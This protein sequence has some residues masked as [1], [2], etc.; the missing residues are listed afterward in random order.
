[1]NEM[2]GTTPNK[3]QKLFFAEDPSD[4]V[5]FRVVGHSKLIKIDK[6]MVTEASPVIK[7]L[8]QNNVF[9][10]IKPILI[11][12]TTDFD[13]LTGFL[14]FVEALHEKDPKSWL[15]NPNNWEDN[16]FTFG[17]NRVR[18]VHYFAKK[19]QVESLIDDCVLAG[20]DLINKYVKDPE[21]AGIE[22]PLCLQLIQ[23]LEL[24]QAMA[25]VKKVTLELTR[26]LVLEKFELAKKWNVK[27]FIDQV[28]LFCCFLQPEEDWPRE[29][30]VLVLEQL[31]K[32]DVLN[33]NAL[34]KKLKPAHV[35]ALG[36]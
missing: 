4:L 33:K 2:N 20:D 29:L 31:R 9:N 13:V 36:L 6:T 22:L 19:Y 16:G 17:F 32:K 7:E 1:M 30:L 12:D 23:D 26:T 25:K 10:E 18:M 5:W 14:S 27:E 24:K 34:K 35:D 15:G 3:K 11:E 8:L 28:V 21:L